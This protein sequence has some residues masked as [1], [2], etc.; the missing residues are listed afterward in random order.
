MVRTTLPGGRRSGRELLP[1]S[2]PA[3]SSADSVWSAMTPQPTPP[4][5]SRFMAVLRLTATEPMC[6]LNIESPFLY[7][8]LLRR[9]PERNQLAAVSRPADRDDDILLAVEH[10]RHRRTA[11]GGRHIDGATLPSGRFVERAQHRATLARR[12]GRHA[13]IAAHHERL[14]DDCSGIARLSGARN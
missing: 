7:H 1:N 9:Q 5:S 4:R 14:G 12:R 8:R 10:V 3:A 2:W 6:R 11:L 13:R